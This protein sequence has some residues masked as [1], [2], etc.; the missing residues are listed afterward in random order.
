MIIIGRIRAEE[1]ETMAT[2]PS[3]FTLEVV[4]LI[5]GHLFITFDV[6][7]HSFIYVMWLYNLFFFFFLRLSLFLSESFPVDF[8]SAT[9]CRE[10][11]NK[12]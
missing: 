9:I 7:I 2:R 11:Q 3:E 8:W 6:F 1:K 5:F 4:V 10:E 12:T